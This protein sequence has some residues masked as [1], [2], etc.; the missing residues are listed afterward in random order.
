MVVYH[1]EGHVSE[2]Q[3]KIDTSLGDQ[4]VDKEDGMDKLITYLDT[5]YVEDDMTEAWSKYKK[6][7]RLEKKQ[8]QPVTE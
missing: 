4:I 7:V 3:E 2:I 6:F 8:E 5:I 1:L